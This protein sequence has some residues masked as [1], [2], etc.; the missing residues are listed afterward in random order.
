M[1]KKTISIFE[2]LILVVACFAFAYLMSDRTNIVSAQQG[3]P[4][5]GCCEV[6]KELS[7]HGGAKCLQVTEDECESGFSPNVLCEDSANCKL[8]CCINKKGECLLIYASETYLYDLAEFV[9]KDENEGG[10]SCIQVLNLTGG[11]G[12]GI[13]W[14]YKSKTETVGETEALMASAIAIFPK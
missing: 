14:R 10:L 6:T 4:V 5:A 7:D 13:L 8:G 12:A 2:I 9:I 1:K 11:H 3:T